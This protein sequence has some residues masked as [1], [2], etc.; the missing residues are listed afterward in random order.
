MAKHCLD[1][2]TGQPRLFPA[3]TYY[4]QMDAR[5]GAQELELMDLVW[6]VWRTATTDLAQWAPD[7]DEIYIIEFLTME[8]PNDD[9]LN[10]LISGMWH[11]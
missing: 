6:R 11:V 10:D 9:R 1:F 7:G 5:Y 4:A 3:G 8:T 2:R